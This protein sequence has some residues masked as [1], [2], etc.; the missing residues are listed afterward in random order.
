MVNNNTHVHVRIES[1]IGKVTPFMTEGI[2]SSS[3]DC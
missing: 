1:F 2:I 3:R